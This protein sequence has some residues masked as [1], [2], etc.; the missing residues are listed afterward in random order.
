LLKTVANSLGHP[1]HSLFQETKQRALSME[2]DCDTALR[3]HINTAA[4]G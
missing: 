3:H 4:M 2:M 1:L